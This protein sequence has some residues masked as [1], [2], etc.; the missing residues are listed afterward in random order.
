MYLQI[1]TPSTDFPLVL[2]VSYIQ[3]TLGLDFFFLNL[4]QQ[5]V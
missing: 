1:Q 3:V 4:F 2:A 5:K